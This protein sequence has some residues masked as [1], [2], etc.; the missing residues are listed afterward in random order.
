[1][2]D[3]KDNHNMHAIIAGLGGAALT[4]N[5]ITG[6]FIGGA[7]FLYMKKYQHQN[8]VTVIKQILD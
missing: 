3:F 1:M 7:F 5:V 6:L 8:P 2:T 4:Q